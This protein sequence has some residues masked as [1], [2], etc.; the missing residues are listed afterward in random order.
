MNQQYK[1]ST[2]KLHLYTHK[3][4]LNTEF[5]DNVSPL[6]LQCY[7]LQHT[8]YRQITIVPHYGIRQCHA[9]GR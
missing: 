5:M 6:Y 3:I 9:V 7:I 4:L 1:C 2:L 8:A